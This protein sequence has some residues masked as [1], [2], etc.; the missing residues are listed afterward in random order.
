[1]IRLDDVHA[2]Y[3]STRVLS[4]VSLQVSRGTRVALVGSSGC[5]KSTL[6][7]LLL[8]LVAPTSGRVMV[9]DTEVTP[10]SVEGIRLR[11]GY[12][13]QDGG[14]FP[15]LT[16]LGNVSLVALWLGWKKARI[17][18]RAR[19][20]FELVGLAP[21]LAERYP[22]ELSGGQRQRVGLVRAL[23]LDP[24]VLLMDEPLG[25]LDPVLRS[26]M[27]RDLLE[28]F[29]RLKKTVLLVTHDMQE[30]AFLADEIAVMRAGKILQRGTFEELSARP[31]DPFV[32]ELVGAQG[33][34]A[35]P[36]ASAEG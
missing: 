8:G 13:I 33:R 11:C 5:G 31:A 27:Q 36:S 2:S 14:L 24:D 35:T 34:P 17:E 32:A 7:R 10:A 23:A 26:R 21:E 9:A 29:L 1:V 19:E 4:G 3:G 15:H 22:K 30:A 20:L 16:V 28:L 25:A 6:L 12:V 18:A